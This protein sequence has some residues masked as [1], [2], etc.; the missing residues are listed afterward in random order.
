MTQ[1]QNKREVPLN[2]DTDTLEQKKQELIGQP[3]QEDQSAAFDESLVEHDA[4][5]TDSDRLYS[6]VEAGEV[7]TDDENESLDLMLDEELRADETDNPMEA[8]EE[9]Y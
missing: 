3:A 7:E 8:A 4:Q 2:G 5:E 1:R 9:G 6:D